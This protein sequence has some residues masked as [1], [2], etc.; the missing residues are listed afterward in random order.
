MELFGDQWPPLFGETMSYRLGLT[1]RMPP[2]RH[3]RLL[4]GA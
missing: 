4:S 3:A 1:I 2:A